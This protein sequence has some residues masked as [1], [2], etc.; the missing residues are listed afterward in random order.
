MKHKQIMLFLCVTAICYHL[1]IPAMAQDDN[2]VFTPNDSVVYQETLIQENEPFFEDTVSEISE[3]NSDFSEESEIVCDTE[4]NSAFAPQSNSQSI[5]ESIILDGWHLD[6]YG[7]YH[8]YQNG[9]HLRNT[10]AEIKDAAGEIHAYYFYDSGCLYEQILSPIYIYNVNYHNGYIATDEFGHLIKGW[11]ENHQFY[12]GE[13]YFR[14]ENQMLDENGIL[15]Y[16]GNEGKLYTNTTLVID[17]TVYVADENGHLTPNDMSEKSEWVKTNDC[18]YLY[19]NGELIKNQLYKLGENTYYF[20]EDGKMMTGAFYC[21]AID[22]LFADQNGVIQYT[23][24]WYLLD[25]NW[26]Y[27]N[28][29]G[30]AVNNTFYTINNQTYY[31]DYYGRMKTGIFELFHESNGQWKQDLYFAD[32]SG[33]IP[34]YSGW[35]EINN[36]W[37]YSFEDG[38]LARDCFILNDNY[39][40]NHFGQM[41]IGIFEV[42]DYNSKSTK[43]YAREDGLIL[44]NQW[45]KDGLFYYY[46]GNDGSL[47]TEKWVDDTYYLDK[48]GAMVIGSY[49]IKGTIYKF[50][51]SGRKI[52]T[53]EK[54]GWQLSDGEWYYYTSTGDIVNGWLY[55]NNAWY[56][57]ENSLMITN[58]EISETETS[59]CVGYDGKMISNQW[60]NWI[61]YDLWSYATEDGSLAKNT[62]KIIDNTW[63]YFLDTIMLKNTASTIDGTIHLFDKNGAWIDISKKSGWIQTDKENWYYINANGTLNTKNKQ[64]I[65][66]HTYYFQNGRLRTNTIENDFWIDENGWIDKTDG[67]KT[68]GHT[69]VYVSDGKIQNGLIT[70]QEK[71]YYLTP[72]LNI[73]IAQINNDYLNY[74][75][76]FFDSNGVQQPLKEGWM[77]VEYK[78]HT[79]WYFLKNGKPITGWFN[80]YHFGINGQ[81]TTGRYSNLNN[82]NRF[83]FYDENGYLKKNGWIKDGNFWYYADS[84]GI[85]YTGERIIDGKTY[86]FDYAGHWVN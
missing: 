86:F 49:E 48:Y 60:K 3:T 50:D 22:Y 61:S 15:Y 74:E 39:Y 18:W 69:W 58:R 42:S 26:Y 2:S 66:G 19:I 10:I 54:R 33:V 24:S 9:E 46:T 76:S 31:F 75:Y 81:L 38:T 77:S 36:T 79:Q 83:Y 23:N 20:D 16:F 34:R 8:Y 41:E 7:N 51:N 70:L 4:K 44:K 5:Q 84:T 65:D 17:G 30:Y 25:G 64:I 32:S 1:S 35:H 78:N 40:I 72:Y 13:N 45:V 82:Q 80:D 67:W 53:V 73:G 62:W 47:L 57:L 27:V 21:P 28:E 43:Y 37:Y 14:Y 6:E 56:Y 12:Y 29:K 71:Q 11:D 85:L 63:Y 59:Y 52:G 68:N 55:Y